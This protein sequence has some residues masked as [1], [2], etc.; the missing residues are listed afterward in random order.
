MFVLFLLNP[1]NLQALC[2]AALTRLPALKQDNRL[3][4]GFAD[5][6]QNA[7]CFHTG[8]FYYT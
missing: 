6:A 1:V 3:W 7:I 4:N 2:W 5:L 8:E